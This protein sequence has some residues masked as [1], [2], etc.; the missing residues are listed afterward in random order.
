M[1]NQ[2]KS[3][4]S[5]A[6]TGCKTVITKVIT[7]NTRLKPIRIIKEDNIEVSSLFWVFGFIS[8]G[9]GNLRKI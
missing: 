9:N 6:I 2:D 7:E 1:T 3:F 5:A 8:F 4:H